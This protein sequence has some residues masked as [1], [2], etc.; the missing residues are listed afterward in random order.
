LLGAAI[1]WLWS[2]AA[3]GASALLPAVVRGRWPVFPATPLLVA[4]CALGWAAGLPVFNLIQRQVERSAD[5]YAAQVTSPAAGVAFIAREAACFRQDY[6][7]TLYDRIFT[8]NHPPPG[9]R[10]AAMD[11]V[12]RR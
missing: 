3:L 2:G 11:A 6:S 4:G 8:L 5:V 7:P 10:I 12:E 1:G 9:E